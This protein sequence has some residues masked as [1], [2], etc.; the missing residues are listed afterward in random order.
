[1]NRQP[2][3]EKLRDDCIIEALCEIRFHTNEQP[4]IVIGRLSDQEPWK[5][6]SKNRLPAA[7]LP[8]SIRAL[9]EQLKFQPVLE[10]RSEDG[11]YLFKVG[12]NVISYHNVGKYC[13]W[14][15]FKPAL[16]RVF[17]GLFTCVKDV[18]VTRLGF[19]YLNAITSARHYISNVNGLNIDVQV[20]GSKV[21][22]PINLNYLVKND[23]AHV[24][25]TRI[26]SP[27]FVQ[28][29]LPKDTAVVVDIDVSS[30]EGYRAKETRAVAE[31]SSSA[32]DF[33]KEAFFRLIPKDILAK[34]QEK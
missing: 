25:M 1:M 8:S 4:E 33:E 9:N 12:S 3:P 31:W 7:E 20:A 23:D 26:A 17:E 18:E 30:Q 14:P 10:L 29:P 15:T 11:A 5:S 32:H 19:R 22:E 13:G 27:H 28:G 16:D 34:L 21:G 2:L 24:T 6:F